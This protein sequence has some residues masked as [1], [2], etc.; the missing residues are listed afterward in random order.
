MASG[1]AGGKAGACRPNDPALG[2]GKL[3]QLFA[4]ATKVFHLPQLLALIT[5]ARRNP[6]VPT[7]LVVRILF[8]LGL[9]RIRSFNA[10]EPQLAEPW[11]QRALGRNPTNRKLA[12]VDAL[13]YSLHRMDESTT[14]EACVRVI[15]KAER[16]KVFREGSYG[17]LRFVAIDGWEPYSSYQR[18]C[19]ACLTRQ[20]RVGDKVVTQYYHRY[21]V[22][23]LLGDKVEVVVDM[24]PVRSADQRLEHNEKNVAG[25]EGELTAAKR[26]IPRLRSEYGNLLDVLVLDALYCNGPIF[27]LAAQHRFGVIAVAK[28]QDNEPLKEAMS[29]WGKQPAQQQVQ[30]KDKHERVELWDAR[31][32]QTLMSYDGPIRV[33]RALVHNDSGS[34]DPTNW[35]FA[36]T[37]KATKLSAFQVSRAGRSRWHIENTA[38]YQFAHYWHFTHVFTHEGTA[39]PSLLWIF[40]L[41]FNLLQLFIYRQLGGY[42][43]DRGKDPTRTILRLVDEFKADLAR[44]AAPLAWNT[45]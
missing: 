18:H 37:G 29:L 14:R 41:A 36:V 43:R 21:V 45:S 1:C 11:M 7:E 5:D 35:C 27:S 8:V 20:V 10:L 38:F 4:Y 23:L 12:S 2:N 31:D 15:Q 13:S 40:F 9:V 16:N 25:H 26:L 34:G 17:A 33:V 39:L 44:L 42:G 28:K 3:R 6:R 32:I 30:D 22:A 24:E 19:P